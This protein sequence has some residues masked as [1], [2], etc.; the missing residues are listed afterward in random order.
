MRVSIVFAMPIVPKT[1][2]FFYANACFQPSRAISNGDNNASRQIIP[3]RKNAVA[4]VQG[5]PELERR[6]ERRRTLRRGTS[7]NPKP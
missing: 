7:L 4:V 3:A 1:L 6:H 5:F 2:I